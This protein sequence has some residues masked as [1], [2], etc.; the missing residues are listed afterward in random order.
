VRMPVVLA[1]AIAVAL[2]A[3]VPAVAAPP[4]DFVGIVAEDVFWGTPAY[5]EQALA[6]HRQL[7]VQVI[8]Q[9]FDW[10]S[11]ETAPGQYDFTRQDTFVAAAA[12]HGIRIVPVLFRPPAF[13]ARASHT[14]RLT[15]PPRSARDMGRF[16]AAIARRFGPQ[17]SL[18]QEVPG[19][20][21][22]P[23][24]A[25]QVWNEPNLPIYWPRRPSARGYA[26]LLRGVARGVKSVD[27]RAEIVTAGMPQSEFKGS[28]GL[29]KYIN[30]LYRAGA[31]KSFDTLAVNTYARNSRELIKLLR[32]VRAT[33]N[34]HRDRRARLW[35]S[36]FG[37]SDGGPRSRF[38]LD[39]PGQAR[40]V[41]ASIR[42]MGTNRRTLKLSGFVYW[43][44]KDAPPYRAGFDFWGLH[45]GL[46]SQQ[47]T[48][49]PALTAF[50]EAVRKLR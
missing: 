42:A 14:D 46:L 26:A 5:R 13:H 8:R 27:A 21:R 37:W 40:N 28:V 31:G 23:I 18:W 48:P 35:A 38:R 34:R 25:Y 32:S 7:G 15:Y 41:A 22:L 45:A 11:I 16:G 6:A 4:R 50:A 1:T 24:T 49:K 33:M 2:T 30:Q 36:E 47:G 10:S 39:P 43:N 44:W 17:G 29:L 20:P 9:T 19:L 12:R 3:S